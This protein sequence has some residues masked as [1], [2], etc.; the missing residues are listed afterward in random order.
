MIRL[1]LAQYPLV[2]PL[3]AELDFNLVIRSVVEGNTPAWVFVDDPQQPRSVL[4]WDRQDAIFLAGDPQDGPTQADLREVLMHSVLPNARARWIP[5]MEVCGTPSGWQEVL[6]QLLPGL[7]GAAIR[8]LDFTFQ[9]LPEAWQQPA[10]TRAILRRIDSYLLQ[11]AYP[12]LAYVRGWI[13][14]F[15][16]TPEDFHQR[17]FG[18]CALVGDT[19]AAWCLTVFAA[20]NEREVGLETIADYRGQGLATLVASATIEAIVKNGLVPRWQCHSGNQPSLT[21]AEKVGFVRTRE[22]E[23]YRFETAQG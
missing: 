2:L 15:W 5:A 21:V 13:D 8:R 10:P 20:G 7:R 3:L 1:T 14:S 12:N 16:H 23:A 4:L 18:Y 6:P 9:G 19:V 17:G 11:S 22:Y